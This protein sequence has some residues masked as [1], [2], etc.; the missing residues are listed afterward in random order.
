[1]TVIQIVLG[2][3]GVACVVFA[4]ALFR[5]NIRRGW[6]IWSL[7]LAPALMALA[8]SSSGCGPVSSPSHR[9]FELEF[10]D[11]LGIGASFQIICY[12]QDPNQD[13]IFNAVLPPGGTVTV[14][15]GATPQA[16]N[17]QGAIWSG[18]ISGTGPV[19]WKGESYGESQ[20]GTFW[21]FHIEYPSGVWWGQF[22]KQ[23]P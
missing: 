18:G 17:I 2:V 12:Y 8:L 1:M 21:L 22:P 11:D 14:V 3:I 19:F 7:L 20:F 6:R 13:Q 4:S 15:V 23:A 5:R 9:A 16:I 10:R